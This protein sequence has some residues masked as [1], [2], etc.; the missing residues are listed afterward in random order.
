M[1]LW[2]PRSATEALGARAL[3]TGAAVVLARG[4][5]TE[6]KDVTFKPQNID[7]TCGYK[8]KLDPSN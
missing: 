4:K 2:S 7:P 6:F 1:Q 8:G 5:W 3:E